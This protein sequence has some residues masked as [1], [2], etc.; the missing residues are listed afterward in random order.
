MN[1]TG[2]SMLKS[3]KQ[4]SITVA[5]LYITLCVFPFAYAQADSCENAI[6]S[7]NAKLYPK[8][9]TLELAEIVRNLNSTN[10]VNLPP[11]FLT[12]TQAQAKGWRPGND[13]WS[14]SALKGKSIGGDQF[15]NIEGKL[16]KNKT[17][18]EADL[19]Y[20]GGHRG[21]KRIVFSKDGSRYITV[22]HYQSFVKLPLCQ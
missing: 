8:I 11:K 7:I 6:K 18:R 3:I 17:W 22:D 13:L 1:I 20:K 5:L 9:D 19:D 14:M 2:G 10:N 12:K 16:P 21:S 4:G 15:K